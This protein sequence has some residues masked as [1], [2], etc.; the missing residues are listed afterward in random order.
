MTE[1]GAVT[2]VGVALLSLL[3]FVTGTL[4]WIG[5]LVVAHRRAQSAADLAALAGTARAGSCA[6]AAAV[7]ARN[8]ATMQDC[9]VEGAHLW[10]TV[11]V[12]APS[13]L[14]HHPEVVARAHAGP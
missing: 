3:L 7:A 11:S 2:M 10:V 8:Q 9:R 6:A 13:L 14:G 12:A 5:A 1:R 4:A